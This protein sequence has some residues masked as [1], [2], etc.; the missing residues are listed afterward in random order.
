MGNFTHPMDHSLIII[1][2]LLM[3]HTILLRVT[4]TKL[5]TMAILNGL[6]CGCKT[7]VRNSYEYLRYQQPKIASKGHTCREIK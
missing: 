6:F 5:K 2:V 3:I 7:R 4:G 1:P